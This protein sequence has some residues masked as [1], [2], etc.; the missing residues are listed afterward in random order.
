[1]VK[2]KNVDKVIDALKF[3]FDDVHPR[4]L[5]KTHSVLVAIQDPSETNDK[6]ALLAVEPAV[7]YSP[8]THALLRDGDLKEFLEITRLEFKK[9]YE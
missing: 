3:E 2:P 8:E 5:T 9:I 7:S 6:F 4:H 1:M